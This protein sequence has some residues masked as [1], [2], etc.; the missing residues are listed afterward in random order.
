MFDAADE[1]FEC[2]GAV[3]VQVVDDGGTDCCC[4]SVASSSALLVSEFGTSAGGASP[5]QLWVLECGVQLV[6]SY[7]VADELPET[8]GVAT[9]GGQVV[10]CVAGVAAGAVSSVVDNRFELGA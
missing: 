6:D 4:S 7:F 1:L 8:G 3:V 10:G 5:T 9:V 2:G